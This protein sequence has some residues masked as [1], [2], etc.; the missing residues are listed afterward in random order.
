[1]KR[2]STARPLSMHSGTKVNSYFF[3]GVASFAD[4]SCFTSLRTYVGLG[5]RK[6]I[7]EV[8]L[9]GQ[10]GQQNSKHSCLNVSSS[11]CGYCLRSFPYELFIK[12]RG[13]GSYTSRVGIIL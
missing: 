13:D 10:G 5:G 7:F 12:F 8:I 1:M 11:I 3:G 6:A 4:S 2:S 9:D